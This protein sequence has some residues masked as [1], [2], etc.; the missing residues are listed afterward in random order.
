MNLDP[1]NHRENFP[2]GIANPGVELTS[3]TNPTTSIKL[4]DP[5]ICKSCDNRGLRCPAMPV[6]LLENKIPGMV[7]ARP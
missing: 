6:I 4:I 7:P 3:K 5:K 2:K 1:H